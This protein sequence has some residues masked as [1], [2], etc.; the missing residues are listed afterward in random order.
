MNTTTLGPR[1][2]RLL[3]AG[4]TVAAVTALSGCGSDSDPDSATSAS[5]GASASGSPSSTA[6]VPASG[7]ALL[8]AAELVL[9]KVPGSTLTS[10]ETD[11]GGWEVQIADAEGVESEAVVSA[12]GDTIT[13]GPTRQRDDAQDRTEHQTLVKAA[14]VSHTDAVSAIG[15]AVPGSI[16]EL[17]LDDYRGGVVWEADVE[18]AGQPTVSL[19]LDA[20]TGKV[21]TK[22]TEQPGSD[23]D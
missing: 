5:T 23:D 21:L 18:T 22:T 13:T 14:T 6:S 2:L 15:Q 17:N 11:P 7:T 20:G 1:N 10:I 9:D 8:A 19:R 4:T 3:A 16:T 12:N